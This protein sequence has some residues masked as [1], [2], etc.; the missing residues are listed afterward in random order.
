MAYG[1]DRPHGDVSS[2]ILREAL[3]IDGALSDSALGQLG[4]QAVAVTEDED[5]ATRFGS[6]AWAPSRA[7]YLAMPLEKRAGTLRH[8]PPTAVQVETNDLRL[9][10]VAP[11]DLPV[12]CGRGGS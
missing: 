4:D 9:D 11:A 6:C 10:V 3:S 8:L 7:S 12:P 1:T 5:T 2:R